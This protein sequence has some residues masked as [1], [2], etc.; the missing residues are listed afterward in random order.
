MTK[1]KYGRT[2]VL[3]VVIDPLLFE[4]GRTTREIA[5]LLAPQFVGRYDI[6]AL[7]NNIRSRVVVLQG[8]GYTLEKGADKKIRLVQTQK[9]VETTTV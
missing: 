3:S 2:A 7:I 9:P 1:G 5:T 6:D 8:R 4:G